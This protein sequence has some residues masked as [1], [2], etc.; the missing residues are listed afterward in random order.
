MK[1]AKGKAVHQAEVRDGKGRVPW[2]TLEVRRQRLEVFPPAGKRKRYP[3][4]PLTVIHARERNAP[5]GRS[6]VD[7]RW[8]TNLPV[9]ARAEALE[10][11][12]RHAMRWKIET[13]HKILKSGCRAEASKLRA[14]GRIVN[15]IAVFCILS[16]RIFRMTMM[17][18]VA[19]AAPSTLAITETETRLLDRLIPDRTG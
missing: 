17:N 11:L 15:R 4:L 5:S 2:A 8:I 7:W 10:K 13:F 18:R 14:S 1:D 6:P 16:W 12:S 9:R 19:P 3:S